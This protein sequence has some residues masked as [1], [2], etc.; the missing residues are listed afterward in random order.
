MALSAFHTYV[1]R[2]WLRL[3][4][5]VTAKKHLPCDS[6]S[7]LL[8]NVMSASATASCRFSSATP[9]V[10]LAPGRSATC[11]GMVKIETCDFDPRHAVAFDNLPSL[12]GY[13]LYREHSICKT[14]KRCVIF[15]YLKPRQQ[16]PDGIMQPAFGGRNPFNHHAHQCVVIF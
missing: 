13:Y 12:R 10:R 4:Y 14:V 7:C 16:T 1:V 5:Q 15:T 8:I 6:S 11:I 9:S 3:P 2:S